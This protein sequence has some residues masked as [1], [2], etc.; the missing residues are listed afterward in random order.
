M[1]G[2]RSVRGN[3]RTF[4]VSKLPEES[5]LKAEM[6]KYFEEPDKYL[7]LNP[8]MVVGKKYYFLFFGQYRKIYTR[9]KDNRRHEISSPQHRRISKRI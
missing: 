1:N 8:Y 4:V 3:K 5:H 7:K 6:N 2:F 9:A